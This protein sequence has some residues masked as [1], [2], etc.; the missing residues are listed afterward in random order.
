MQINEFCSSRKKD[1]GIDIVA[2]TLKKFNFKDT[3]VV[4]DIGSRDA[5][6]SIFLLNELKTINIVAFEP[7]P[8]QF[9]VCLQNCQTTN[10]Q[11]RIKV[12]NIAL[13]NTHSK[14]KFY[15]TPGN[16]GASS[17]LEPLHVPHTQ[18][19]K[20]EKIE[21]DCTTLD[22]YCSEQNIYP[23]IIWMDVQGNELNTLKGGINTIKNVK[24]IYSEVGIK[25]YYK[26]HTLKPQIMKFLEENG[27]IVVSEH[28]EWP[29]V[30]HNFVFVNK[31]FIG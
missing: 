8:K 13:S 27:F 18:N 7:N 19:Q 30:E 9:E 28:E 5:V 23:D 4:F 14:M 25:T 16:I 26:N 21:V 22:Q 2:N 24:L 11:D 29:E 1:E 3:K 31:Q 6:E 10:C 20:I 17:L 15:I 12:E